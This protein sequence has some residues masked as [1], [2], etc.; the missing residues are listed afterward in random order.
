[1]S[2][3][4]TCNRA[5]S[6]VGARSSIDSLT[7]NSAEARA[8]NLHFA[9]V[10]DGLLRMANWD[11]ATRTTL[12]ALMKSAPGTPENQTPTSG[13]T[14]ALPP[15]PWLYQYQYPSDC[16]RVQS[17]LP[18]AASDGATGMS[19]PIFSTGN[20][21][22]Y[23]GRNI[24]AQRFSVTMDVDDKQNGVTVLL[25]NQRQ[26]IIEY[27]AQVT[28]AEMFDSLFENAMSA[29]LAAAIGFSLTGDKGLQDRLNK[30]V[31]QIVMQ[32]RISD[33]DEGLTVVDYMPDFM[34]AR[35]GGSFSYGGGNVGGSGV[36]SEPYGLSLG[37]W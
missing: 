12:A 36:L 23:F 26:A 6:A 25:T 1:M 34:R 5:L 35:T 30:Q 27:T 18:Q 32:A 3:V 8:C 14:S 28:N 16:L 2:T 20:G 37:I 31:T 29:A 7:E 21:S 10:R 4:D 13:W 11:F 24:G 19:V 9:S 15:P 22:S 33:G 17:V